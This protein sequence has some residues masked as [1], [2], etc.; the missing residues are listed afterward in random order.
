MVEVRYGMVMGYGYDGGSGGMGHGRGD[1]G[2]AD[3]GMTMKV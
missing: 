3:A 2:N 1:A